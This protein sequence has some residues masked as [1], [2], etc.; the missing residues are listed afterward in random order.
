MDPACRQGVSLEEFSAGLRARDVVATALRDLA[1][2]SD[3]FLH[4]PGAERAECD[5][6]RAGT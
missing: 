1:R 6:A 5:A 3:L 2:D 4:R